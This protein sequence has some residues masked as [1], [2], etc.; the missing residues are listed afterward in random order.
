MEC[1]S[2]KSHTLL[3][4]ESD[5]CVKIE[6]QNSGE[7]IYW[8]LAQRGI[9]F[10]CSDGTKGKITYDG[11]WKIEVSN[12]GEFFDRVIPLIGDTGKHEGI[13]FNCTSY[14]D[15][16]VLKDGVFWIKI[17]GKKI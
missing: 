17:N 5:D 10:E 9:P 14:S 2:K 4:G 15:V 11:D 8:A 12:K 1:Q 13:A 7:Y 3:Y 16:L 6:G